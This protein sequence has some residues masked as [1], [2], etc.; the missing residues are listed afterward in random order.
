RTGPRAGEALDR[1]PVWRLRLLRRVGRRAGLRL[2][3][4]HQRRGARTPGSGG[5][6]PQARR[7]VTRR[8]APRVCSSCVQRPPTARVPDDRVLDVALQPLPVRAL[9]RTGVGVGAV[10]RRLAHTPSESQPRLRQTVLPPRL[11]S[12]LNRSESTKTHARDPDR[13]GKG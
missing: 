1:G 10:G 11:T 9:A 5:T 8:A 13:P 4:L 3:G 12:T 7:T 2:G 6:A